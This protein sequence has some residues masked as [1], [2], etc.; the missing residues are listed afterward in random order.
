MG[1]S[2]RARVAIG[3]TLTA[4]VAVFGLAGCTRDEAGGSGVATDEALTELSWEAQ[5]LESIGFAPAD[6]VPAG[7]A[8]ADP[9]PT[10]SASPDRKG[11]RRDGIRRHKRLRFAFGRN[12]LHGEAVVQT[13]EGVRTVVVQRGTVTA[14]DAESITVKSADGFTLTWTFGDPIHVI[15]HRTSVRPSELS[16]GA[17]VGV[18]GAKNGDQAVAR[19]IVVP[20]PR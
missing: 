3:I 9:A 11:D 15:E 13:A 19:L 16:V 12:V 17:T 5:A 10:A 2:G 1:R 7:L 8:V 4:A 18:A 6:L 14:I 20:R